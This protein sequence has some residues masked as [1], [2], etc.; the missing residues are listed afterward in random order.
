MALGASPSEVVRLIVTGALY[1]VF[2]G[3]LVGLA[4]LLPLSRLQRVYLYDVSPMDPAAL[5]IAASILVISATVAAYVP[6]RRASRIDPLV[7]LRA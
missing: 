3:A 2:G 5:S 6:A 1:P 7:A 4:A